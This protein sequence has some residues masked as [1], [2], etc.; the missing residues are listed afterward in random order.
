MDSMKKEDLIRM[1]VTLWAIWH[2]KRK[3]IFEDIYQCPMVTVAFVNRFLLDLEA[4]REA[5]SSLV[6]KVTDLSTGLA[7]KSPPIKFVTLISF[8]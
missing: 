1:L 7:E 2:A 8:L 4:T 6:E 3:V 5:P